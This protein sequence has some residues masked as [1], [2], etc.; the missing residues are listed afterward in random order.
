MGS[1]SFLV[2]Y[3]DTP[4]SLRGLEVA[5]DLTRGDKKATVHAVFVVE[6]DRRLPLDADL[7]EE[8]AR[9]ERCLSRAEEIARRYKAQCHGDILQARDAGH[10]IVDEALERGVDAIVMG[11]ERSAREGTA[12]E[13]GKTAEFVLRHAPCEV[14]LV[15]EAAGPA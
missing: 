9:G 10:A 3:I 2:P 5:F 4:A 7:P 8:S 15:R 14:I 13:V 11:V 12:I 1:P 6:V